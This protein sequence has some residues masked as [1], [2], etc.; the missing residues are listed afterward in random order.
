[1]SNYF[2]FFFFFDVAV[3]LSG[4]V[5]ANYNM[6]PSV[7]TEYSRKVRERTKK[8]S[9]PERKIRI[10]EEYENRGAYV[11]PGVANAAVTKFSN[12]VVSIFIHHYSIVVIIIIIIILTKS[13]NFINLFFFSFSYFS[14]RKRK[15]PWNKRLRVCRKTNFWIYFSMHSR[16]MRIGLFEV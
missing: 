16:S 14:K 7:N 10:L 1:M 4:T 13:F 2:L 12:L 6:K 3:A 15:S 9:K 11:P 8:A 5:K